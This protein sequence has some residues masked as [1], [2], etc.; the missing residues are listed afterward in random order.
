MAAPCFLFICNCPVYSQSKYLLYTLTSS[1]KMSF[2]V[3][4]F[5]FYMSVQG[6]W[7][8]HMDDVNI[9]ISIL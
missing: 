6:M 5:M 1:Y 9:H 7:D 4:G 8:K 2:F 3:A